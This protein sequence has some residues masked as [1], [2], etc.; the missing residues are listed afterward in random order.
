MA[1]RTI[2][3]LIDQANSTLAD[4]LTGDISPG[5]IRTLI[6][7]LLDTVAP[8]YGGLSQTTVTQNVTAT[9]APLVMGAVVAHSSAEW[10]C[11]PASATLMRVV[12][13]AAGGMTSQ[14]WITGNVSGPNNVDLTVMLYRNAAFS[15]WEN[16][17]TLRGPGIE[18]PFVFNALDA[19]VSSDVAYQLMV[20]ANPT[21]SC[22]FGDVLFI[23]ANIPVRSLT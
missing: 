17:V 11:T 6:N 21:G 2:Q 16:L 9:A 7:D 19:I 5:D 14:F 12:P 15:G 18:V 3:G 8:A 22:V 20:K 13:P 23:G 1:R 10:T 4:N